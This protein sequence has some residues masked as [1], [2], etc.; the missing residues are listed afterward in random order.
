[1][2]KYS[3]I[4]LLTNFSQCINIWPYYGG[5]IGKIKHYFLIFLTNTLVKK[6]RDFQNFTISLLYRMSEFIRKRK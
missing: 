6:N 4:S 2:E 3:T 5:F 1:M